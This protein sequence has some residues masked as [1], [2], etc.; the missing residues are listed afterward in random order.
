MEE[1]GENGELVFHGY[2]VS[3][4]EDEKV[5]EVGGADGCTTMWMYLM[6]LGYRLK[7]SYCGQFYVLY[8][9]SQFLFFKADG[10]MGQRAMWGMVHVPALCWLFL[11]TKSC[12]TL[13][14]P[15]DCS[16][17]GSS[18]YAISQSRI[19][20]W[21]AMSFFRGSSQPRDGIHVSWIGRWIF[22]TADPPGKLKRLQ[23]STNNYND[24]WFNKYIQ[25]MLPNF[26]KKEKIHISLADEESDFKINDF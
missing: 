6:P 25:T 10:G 20:K 3:V 17:P 18:I 1:N 4:W 23:E 16:L 8:I 13:W 14:G 15:V 21:V 7:N 19:L 22:F 2:K 9:L 11:V 12:P 24:F 5:L 26:L